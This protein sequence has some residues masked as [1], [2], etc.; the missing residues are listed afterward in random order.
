MLQL[1]LMDQDLNKVC[2]KQLVD[3]ASFL[4][5]GYSYLSF[6]SLVTYLLKEL[7]YLFYGISHIF[8]YIGGPLYPWVLYLYLWG[9]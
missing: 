4:V 1:V 6:F 3:M 9:S 5:Y 8:D 7:D 2:T